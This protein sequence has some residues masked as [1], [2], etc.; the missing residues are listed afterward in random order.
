MRPEKTMLLEEV[1]QR[2]QDSPYAI[3]TDY[4]GLKVSE[5]SELRKRLRAV[6]ARYTVVKNS[7]LRLAAEQLGWPEFGGLLAGQTA[8]IAG[9]RD[10]CSAAK[11]VKNFAAEF[12][13]PVIRGGVLDGRLLAA[14]DVAA[15]ADLP[16]REVLLARLLSVISAPATQLARIIQ[17]PGA[18]LARVIKAKSDKGDS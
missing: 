12:K 8:I 11:A 4:T 17:T 14:P 3:I 6:G 16:S 10:V 13:R 18:Q 5:I 7:M 15:L 1:K 9:S 2:I